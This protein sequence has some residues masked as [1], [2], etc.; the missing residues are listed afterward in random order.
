MKVVLRSKKTRRYYLGPNEWADTP[1]R[2]LEFN[3]VSQATRFGRDRHLPDIELVAKGY[4]LTERIAMP[5]AAKQRGA[6]AARPA[7]QRRLSHQ[8][9]RS[10]SP[11]TCHPVEG[12]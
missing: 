2:A 11:G 10:D 7:S 4:A 9:H 5:R 6:G 3:S 1:E 8:S 12:V